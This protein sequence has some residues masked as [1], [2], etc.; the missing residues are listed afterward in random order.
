MPLACAACGH[1]L[2][3]GARFCVECGAPVAAPAGP[4]TTD[5]PP[6]RGAPE[7]YTPRHLA[8]RI[9]ASRSAIEGER[10][11][12]TVLFCDVVSSTA[13]AERLDAEAMHG[14]LSRFFE[15]ALVEVHRY[16]GTI[17]QFLGDGFMAL[18]GAPLAHEDHARRAVLAALDL[19][20]AV[21]EHA[22]GVTLRMGVH[23]G[24]VVVG[25][26][27]DNLRMDYTAVGDTTH[28]AARLQQTAEPGTIRISDATERL[29]RGYV[30]VEALGEAPVR[31]RSAPVAAYR[32]T[33]RGTRRSAL[34][35]GQ[36]R[37]SEFV[38]R[39]RELGVLRDLLDDVVAG[40][41]Q[42]VGV[43]GEPGVGKSRLLL[44]LRRGLDARDV[45]WSEG[46]CLSFGGAIPY[47]PILDVVR[48]LC[49]LA[50]MDP[51]DAMQAKV[52]ATLAASGMNVGG[53]APL[54]LHLLGVKEPAEALAG[55]TPEVIKARTA[56]ALRQL[57][58]RRAHGRPLVVALEDLHWIDDASEEFVSTLVDALAGEPILLLATYRPGHR[59]PWTDRSYSTQLS[60][61]RLAE[62]DSLAVVR[63]VRPSA[64][65]T[66]P[67]ARIILAKAEGNPF[68][69]EELARAVGDADPA[70]ATVAVPDTVHG[71]LSARIDR[72][73]DT[74]KR[75]LQA[76]SILGREF[77]GRL[78]E[79]VWDGE[80]LDAHLRE[81]TR[82]EFLHERPGAGER[83]YAFTHALT[84]DV[85]ASTLLG[86]RR[87]ELHRRA[88]QALAALG[89]D[90]QGELAPRLAHHAFEAHAWA[91][92]ARY[93]A[94]A[95]EAARAVYAN[96][97]ALERYDQALTAAERGDLPR[98][99]RL[100]LYE[101]RARVHALLGAFA[102][103]SAD[104]EA[105]LA[106]AR[107]EGRPSA[108]ADL[109]GALAELWGGHKDYQRGLD[110][111]R[112]AVATAAGAADARVL[113]DARVRAGL[114]SLNVGRVTDARHEL[115]RA[116]AIFRAL[117]DT[118]GVAK[119][120]DVLAMAEGVGGNIRQSLVH[121]R[122]ALAHF[123]ALGD[124]TGLPSVAN[125]LAIWLV[126]GGHR[127]EGESLLREAREVARTVGA[128]SDEAFATMGFGLM[129][130]QYGGFGVA[131]REAQAAYDIARDI[132]HREW[133]S[134]ALA[135]LGEVRRECGD[136]AGARAL[137]EEMLGIARDLGGAVWLAGALAYL[138]LDAVELGDFALARAAA[139]EAETAAVE[140]TEY[141]TVAWL[142]R[143]RLAAA[144]G[145]HDAV[146]HWANRVRTETPDFRVYAI[147]ALGLIG[148]ARM[149]RGRPDEAERLLQEATREAAAIDSAPCRWRV[150]LAAADVFTAL[151]RADAARAERATARDL[152]AREAADLPDDLRA[153]FLASAP[154]RRAAAP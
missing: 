19:E 47:T 147:E 133:T 32:V 52:V 99:E 145:D 46:R 58:F 79:A 110:F 63:S 56:D 4:A 103:A 37:L 55:L 89:G 114:M 73:A 150:A 148:E 109:L 136:A 24:F 25:A 48:G 39:G 53:A 36:E 1:A 28:L 106:I 13:L 33:G 23:T 69:L 10:K 124:A 151:G 95:A 60:L 154:V 57:I 34:D 75:L 8:D 122:E 68:F 67:V 92:A 140:V 18:F 9:L 7:S 139:D 138:A 153:C 141:A 98:I 131:L 61:A 35:V 42:A 5:R 137:H 3:A 115:E 27:G 97:E 40:R 107:A 44:E 29:V 49:G 82:Q 88:A 70:G 77:P 96:R 87:R 45:A 62:A 104:Y 126:Y 111:A 16:E 129:H 50:E 93:A 152:L 135:V 149:A 127:R 12:V 80:P 6:A 38:G 15:I 22:L 66:E 100:P 71:V 118:R 123:R 83:T 142:A 108:C 85:A 76:A 105:A 26:I 117:G 101:A 119:T 43:V 54:L 51:P 91:D 128:R 65:A 146:A 144:L 113:A 94:R 120:L 86:A 72:L 84:Q 31:G 64:A 74:P 11:P 21:R 125:T 102:A 116:L 59:P 112:Q 30:E 90:R 14:L 132:G 2:P 41:G 20:R 17:N 78:L 81:L 134:A 130:A 143:A 121:G